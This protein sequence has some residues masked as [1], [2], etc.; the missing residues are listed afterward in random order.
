MAERTGGDGVNGSATAV[1][2]SSSSLIPRVAEHA[3]QSSSSPEGTDYKQV[4]EERTDGW[5]FVLVCNVFI[6]V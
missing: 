4:N 1:S 5:L 3:H 2:G 6:V